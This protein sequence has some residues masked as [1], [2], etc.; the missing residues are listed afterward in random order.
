DGIP[1]P[2]RWLARL[3]GVSESTAG[4]RVAHARLLARLPQFLVA[5]GAGAITADHVAV[6]ARG[7]D[8]VGL[9]TVVAAEDQ[10]V[11]WAVGR[12][13]DLFGRQV[14]RWVLDLH[15]AADR[16][17]GD[18]AYHKRRVSSRRDPASGLAQLLARLPE[19]EHATV[20][21]ALWLLV[22]EQW[23]AQRGT[24]TPVDRQDPTIGQRLA[25]ALVELARRGAAVDA[26]AR[27]RTRPLIIVTIDLQHLLDLLAGAGIPTTLDDGTPISAETAR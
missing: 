19:L 18:P 20:M 5:L 27:E 16:P 25:D 1:R 4:R 3:T 8:E 11:S 12:R 17:G 7:V 10:V 6:V 13:A 9:D 14:R 22:E 2:G 26:A 24:D 21:N 15:D 23:H